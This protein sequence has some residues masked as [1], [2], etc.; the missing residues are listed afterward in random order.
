M[1]TLRVL[2]SV[3]LLAP[4]MAWATGVLLPK[5]TS[6]PA[7]GI[8][9]Q[10]VDINIRD[11]VANVRVDQV[12][13]NSTDRDLEAVYVFPLPEDA[14]ISDFAMTINGKRVS[15]EL[16]PK[17]K[18]RSIYQD[19][20]RR[21]RD[22][23]L[24]EYIGGALFQV[25]VYP[26]QKRS[27]QRIEIAYS[28]T[29]QYDAGL[30]RFV[31]PLRTGDEASRTLE[32]FTVRVGLNSTVPIRT[33]Y[34]PSHDVGISRKGDHEAVIG[35]EENK[36]LLNRD[37]V[38]YYGVSE[39]EF[40][41]N[42]LAHAPK[43]E[44]GF[45]LLMLAPTADPALGK[46]MD[47]DITF[48]I[49][50]SG[51]MAGDKIQQARN[52][53]DYCIRKLNPGD[54]FNIVRFSTDVEPLSSELLPADATGRNR[55]LEFVKKLE[56]RGGTDINGALT[57][58]LGVKTDGKRPYLVAFLTDGMPT[59]G[60][61][62]NATILG[63]LV[64][65]RQDDTRI[66]VFGVGNDVNS[67]L[68]DQVAGNT[69][70]MAMYVAPG[71][72]IETAVSSFYDKVS[73]P[74]LARPELVI[75]KVQCRDVY[76]KALPDLFC[77]GQV[78]VF[79]RYHGS[80]HVAVRL[81]GLVNGEK[82][83]FVYE[84]TFPEESRDNDFIPRLWA[85]RKVGYLL[86]EIRLHGENAELKDEVVRLSREYGIMTPYTSYLV[87]EDDKQ[88][89]RADNG[90]PQPQVMPAPAPTRWLLGARRSE[91]ARGKELAGGLRKARG[92]YGGAVAHDA[93]VA[94]AVIPMEAKAEPELAVAAGKPATE[95]RILSAQAQ[96]QMKQ[97]EGAAAI[98][99]S[100]AIS[101]YKETDRVAQAA[102]ERHIGTRT[103]YL[104]NGVWVDRAFNKK[105]EMK[106]FAYASDEYFKF[107]EAH[108]ELR[109]CFA[110]G[111]KVIICLDEKTAV[112]V[113]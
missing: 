20:V 81:T 56:A 113:E 18:A 67:H 29:L 15:G 65:G 7:L 59:V 6:L 104:L 108:P 49:D 31:F 110:L 70:A 3:L 40:G 9:H 37:F 54:R 112:V 24:L 85:T 77:G 43:G 33:L 60:T 102:A 88:V 80:G 76:P 63:N 28:H 91:E 42:L 69:G 14:S 41:I 96:S 87:V 82:R 61:T 98:A 68:L 111:V 62:D 34:S 90:G 107:V 19:I 71:E 64:K 30:Y 106:K 72:N 74:V 21:M 45:F 25:S 79:G 52:A 66:F 92:A 22:P 83:E 23:G 99:V 39:K 1:R 48:V 27:D 47:K 100:E 12:F 95:A 84:G 10:R 51:S 2:G 38:L 103:F 75:D 36:S 58:A 35:F 44:D 11:G 93:E 32:D 5:D 8:R 16:L 13:F 105:M 73:H 4:S 50:T 97:Q 94:P 46:V 89:V 86:D 26:V 55:A 101:D 57:Q 17:E 53:L 78:R 109:P